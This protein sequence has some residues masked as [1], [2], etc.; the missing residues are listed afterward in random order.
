MRISK[1][2]MDPKYVKRR[3]IVEMIIG[4]ATLLLYIAMIVYGIVK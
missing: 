4:Q 3:T 2:G 1:E